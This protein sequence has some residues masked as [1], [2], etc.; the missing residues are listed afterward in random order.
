MI[1]IVGIF[2]HFCIFDYI[3]TEVCMTYENE[4]RFLCD[5]LKKLHVR[6]YFVSPDDPVEK[7]LDSNSKLLFNGTKYLKT[8]VREIFGEIEDRILY[9]YTFFPCLHSLFILLPS[10]EP[11][12]VLVIGPYFSQTISKPQMLEIGEKLGIAPMDQ[13]FLASI[14]SDIPTLSDD[15]HVFAMLDSFGE[16]IWGDPK[17]FKSVDIKKDRLDTT[18]DISVHRPIDE[19]SSLMATM[20][21]MEKR[22]KYENELMDAVANGQIRKINIL[23]SNFSELGFE[24]RSADPLRNTKNYLIITNTLLRK[25]AER[26]GVHPIYLDGLSS[27]FAIKIEQFSNSN[28]A[29]DMIVEMFNAYCRLVRKHSINTYSPIVQKTI[30]M[31]ESDL[32]ADLSLSALAAAHN[33]SAGYLSTVFKRETGKTLTQFVMEKRIRNA[34]KLLESTHLQI[35]T[36]ALHCGIMDVQ[37]FSKAFKKITGKT[38]KEYRE[39]VR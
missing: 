15:S 3:Y 24:T 35:Q 28:E 10:L 36:I 1:K 19:K 11:K 31:I 22:Y 30:L 37:Y 17:S 9:K 27:S 14:F 34:T 2:N 7:I 38:P 39:S 21:M 33:I 16:R 6:T 20:Q 12:T 18:L 8:P 13:K 32:S 29:R 26:G 23:L 4:M 5:T 25:A